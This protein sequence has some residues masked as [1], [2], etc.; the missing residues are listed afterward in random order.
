MKAAYRII[1]ANFNRARE[2][3]RVIED[4]C[5]FALDSSLLTERVKSLRHKLCEYISRLDSDA[6]IA[7]RDTTNDVGTA[8]SIAL[9]KQPRG[10]SP[11]GPSKQ[12]FRIRSI[13]ESP[14]VPADGP[15]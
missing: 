7:C 12:V 2:G 8:E 5:R 11:R 1:D 6:L 9:K 3:L 10:V 13:Q 14:S 4:Y 15:S